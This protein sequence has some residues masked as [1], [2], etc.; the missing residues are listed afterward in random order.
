MPTND[1]YIK[2]SCKDGYAGPH[3]DTC[4]RCEGSGWRERNPVY[5]VCEACDS[6]NY[7]HGACS[8]CGF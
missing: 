1:L 5:W 2:C 8:H 7:D 3:G 4:T 6:V